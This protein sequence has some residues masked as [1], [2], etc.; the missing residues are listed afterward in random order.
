MGIVY[1]ARHRTLGR[2]VAIKVLHASDPTL[3][4]AE[5]RAERFLREGRAAA[6]VQ[7]SH[8]VD[9]FDFGVDEGVPFL[10]MELVEGETLAQRIARERR[11]SLPSLVELM[12]PV[13]SA[14][15]ELHAAN[16]VHRD[17]KPANILLARERGGEC[18]PK[19]ADF[20]VSRIDVERVLRGEA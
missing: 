5:I 11:L 17:L 3:P 13:L 9:V 18:C 2:R 14:V 12:L 7:H 6:S 10:V 4:G 8:V 1:E 20:G 16:I 19:V 15:A